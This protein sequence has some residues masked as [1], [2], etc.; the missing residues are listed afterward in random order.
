MAYQP[1]QDSLFHVTRLPTNRRSATFRTS[2]GCIAP[3]VVVT[4]EAFAAILKPFPVLAPQKGRGPNITNFN[5]A[6][7]Q[8]SITLS[9]T[10]DSSRSDKDE[11]KPDPR[12]GAY[13]IVHH[14]LIAN[15]FRNYAN[16]NPNHCN[17]DSW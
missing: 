10:S 9:A 8:T 16:R 11:H 3:Q 5:L 1:G 12:K 7:S 15:N 13:R 4:S 14:V 17:A 2:P 6:S